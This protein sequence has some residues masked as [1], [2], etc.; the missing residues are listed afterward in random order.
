[1]PSDL[2]A[3]GATVLSPEPQEGLRV[4]DA[5]GSFD[6]SKHPFTIVLRLE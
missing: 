5:M 2:I 6:L 1:V 4:A 3:I